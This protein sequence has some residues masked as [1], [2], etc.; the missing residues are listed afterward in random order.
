M[1]GCKTRRDFG[2]SPL[3]LRA[4]TKEKTERKT[5]WKGKRREDERSSGQEG[6]A[7]V[8]MGEES[9]RRG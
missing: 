2:L 6:G 9:E 3:H 1:R 8:E 4:I 7:Q 5:E